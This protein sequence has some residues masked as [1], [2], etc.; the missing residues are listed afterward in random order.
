MVAR[1]TVTAALA[2]V[3]LLCASSANAAPKHAKKATPHA[4]V[5]A[6]HSKVKVVNAKGSKAKGKAK[7]KVRPAATPKPA[8]TP[9]P[10][11]HV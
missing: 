7:A 3:C 6:G 10:L 1:S 8:V 5:N 11:S 4:Q 9:R 2:L